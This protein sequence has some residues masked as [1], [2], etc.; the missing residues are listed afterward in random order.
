MGRTGGNTCPGQ[1][2]CAGGATEPPECEPAGDDVR[3]L[4]GTRAPRPIGLPPLLPPRQLHRTLG[5][6]PERALPPPLR[7]VGLQLRRSRLHLLRFVEPQRIR[8]PPGLGSRRLRL[9][10]RTRAQVLQRV[11]GIPLALS[12][13]RRPPRQIRRAAPRVCRLGQVMGVVGQT[14]ISPLTK[15]SNIPSSLRQ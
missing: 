15:S 13:L 1:A 7:W 14:R 4:A 5:P 9:L 10:F 3:E 2:G 12:R 11:P 8:L 6:L